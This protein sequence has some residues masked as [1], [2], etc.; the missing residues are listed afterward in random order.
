MNKISEEILEK[1][2]NIESFLVTAEDLSLAETLTDRFIN[3]YAEVPPLLARAFLGE[4]TALVEL[5]QFIGSKF[6]IQKNGIRYKK[7]PYSLLIQNAFRYL[8]ESSTEHTAD[9]YFL[10]CKTPT[11]I[12]ESLMKRIGVPTRLVIINKFHHHPY[13][14][15]QLKERILRV[16]FM[17]RSTLFSERIANMDEALQEWAGKIYLLPD[18]LSA[19]QILDYNFALRI[20]FYNLA[21]SK[22]DGEN[23]S[24]L[25]D[26]FAE[27][28]GE[29]HEL[30]LS[31]KDF[32]RQYYTSIMTY[33]NHGDYKTAGE[34][35]T[36]ALQ[37][38][39]A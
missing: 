20:A 30:V 23:F 4:I 22:D 36:R 17:P 8:E 33:K 26:Q 28:F 21:S 15:C 16:S 18:D 37:S 9:D 3:T 29:E 19:Y 10:D 7:G 13:I 1:S 25:L 11:L 12:L 39:E 27:R 14:F 6:P 31:W 5:S 34:I 38:D 2:V 32:F 35:I 24:I